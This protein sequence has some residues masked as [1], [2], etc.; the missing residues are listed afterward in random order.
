MVARTLFGVTLRYTECL[1]YSYHNAVAFLAAY[2]RNCHITENK[3]R[4]SSFGI[5]YIWVL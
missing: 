5:C 3:D 1:V 4:T 2:K